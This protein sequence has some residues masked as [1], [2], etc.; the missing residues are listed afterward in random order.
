MFKACFA[1]LLHLTHGKE[2][3]IGAWPADLGF[4]GKPMLKEHILE[5]I[6]HWL[7]ETTTLRSGEAAKKSTGVK[8]IN[9]KGIGETGGGARPDEVAS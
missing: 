4:D 7:Q 6:I 1:S 9:R 5:S 2:L 8:R 3:R